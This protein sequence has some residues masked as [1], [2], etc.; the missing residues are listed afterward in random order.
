V[1]AAQ[2]DVE[3]LRSGCSSQ[4]IFVKLPFLTS[5]WVGGSHEKFASSGGALSDFAALS[6][7]ILTNCMALILSQGKIRGQ[8]VLGQKRFGE[9]TREVGLVKLM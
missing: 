8:N 3:M 9:R 5:I 2:L 1:K 6:V 4:G 7:T